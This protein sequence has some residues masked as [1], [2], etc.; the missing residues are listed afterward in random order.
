[1][2][3]IEWLPLNNSLFELGRIPSNLFTL[4]DE[5]P[6]TEQHYLYCKKNKHSRG[7]MQEDL[8]KVFNKHNIDPVLCKLINPGQD[9]SKAEELNKKLD[10]PQEYESLVDAINN[11]GIYQL[12]YGQF[13]IK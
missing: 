2:H 11:A 3:L 7:K 8:M 13:P 12:W 6:E 4:C 5:G 10:I 1:M 9:I